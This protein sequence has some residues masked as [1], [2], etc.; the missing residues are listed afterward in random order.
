[1]TKKQHLVEKIQSFA[2]LKPNWDSYGAQPL[3]QTVIDLAIKELDNIDCE[4]K[5]IRVSPAP[6]GDIYIEVYQGNKIEQVIGIGK[7]GDIARLEKT[8]EVDIRRS[9]K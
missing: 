6:E 5:Q 2:S 1:M 3:G 8:G 4:N 7:E 9:S